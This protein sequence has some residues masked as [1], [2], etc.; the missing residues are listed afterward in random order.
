MK[1]KKRYRKATVQQNSNMNYSALYRSIFSEEQIEALAADRDGF[2]NKSRTIVLCS[3]ESSYAVHGGLGVIARNMPHWLHESGEKLV[4]CAPL[5][6][7]ISTFRD[8]R[9][10]GALVCEQEDIPVE[11]RN[12]NTRATC[13]RDCNCPYPS[14]FIEIPNLF[15]ARDNPYNYT[16]NH[17]QLLFDSLGF[18]ASI[19]FVLRALGYTRHCLFHVHDWETA[20]TGVFSTIAAVDG[21]LRHTRTVLTVHNSYD[22]YFPLNLQHTFFN[23]ALNGQTVLQCAL[24]FC[25]G[26]IVAVSEPFARELRSDPL[27]H[28]IFIP[29]LQSS[30]ADREVIGIE[31]GTFTASSVPY[32]TAALEEGAR[33][34]I[35]RL[36]R[37]KCRYRNAFITE[38][39]RVS[40]PRIQG[41]ITL[42]PEN[43]TIPILL[44]SGRLD[45]NQK[46]FDVLFNAFRTL[47]RGTCKLFFSPNCTEDDPLDFFTG[48]AREC[49]G[50][51]TIWPFRLSSD[52]LL[53]FYRGASFLV[54]PSLYEPFGAA[55]EGFCMGTPVIARATGGLWKQ[56]NPV[57]PPAIPSFYGT[58]TPQ[59]SSPKPTGILFREQSDG[60]DNQVEQWRRILSSPVERRMEVPLY[61]SLV[62]AAR[63]AL[64]ESIT[65]FSDRR[66]YTTMIYNG[67]MSLEN[68]SWT[69]AIQKYRTVYTMAGEQKDSVEKSSGLGRK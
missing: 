30:I 58:D 51:I 9:S 60:F 37:E 35:D 67:I 50:D 47:P 15:T 41:A 11:S 57:R 1:Q 43:S 13:Y 6:K 14:Y 12:F 64:S 31:N 45:L 4:C 54:M 5:Y 32:S 29:H 18:C 8:A 22:H 55:T 24:P 33:G 61:R 10:E 52:Q 38:I 68:F 62:D 65:I 44:I 19:P 23:G 39:Q 3:L 7:N 36:Y 25:D 34:R 69:N 66:L 28:G 48:I 20:L 26:P 63:C 49:E 2:S 42:N 56:I 59:V 17:L 27:Q 21:V 46:G 53:R 16:S 40:D